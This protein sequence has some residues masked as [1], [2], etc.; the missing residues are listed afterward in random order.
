MPGGNEHVP[1]GSTIDYAFC[2]PTS[3]NH[4]FSSGRG[5]IAYQFYPPNEERAPGGWVHNLEHGAV[6][7]LY[8]NVPSQEVQAEM[9]RW[10]DQ[11]PAPP[12]SACERKVLVARFDQMETAFALVAWGRVLLMDEFDIDT[13]NTF[14]EQWMEHANVPEAMACP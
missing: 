13:A 10:F 4:Y 5:P 1:T 3:G 12:R 14:A 9:R 6:A 7:L 11:A 2:P 8:R